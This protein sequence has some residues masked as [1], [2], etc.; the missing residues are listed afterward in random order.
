MKRKEKAE[1][2]K[3]KPEAYKQWYDKT[4]TDE[5]EWII[6]KVAKQRTRSRRDIGEVNAIKDQM[7]RC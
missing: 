6:Y 1:V 3:A 2:A 5:G 7:G 4:G